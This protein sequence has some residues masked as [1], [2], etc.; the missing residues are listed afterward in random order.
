MTS[1]TE[2]PRNQLQALVANAFRKIEMLESA[3]E[4]ITIAQLVSM[5]ART[6]GSTT[7]IDVFERGER[8]TYSE[9]DR[10]SNKYA[11]AL[12][13]FGVRKHDRIR[14][15]LPNRIAFPILWFAIAKL[16]AVIVP[17]N[18]RYTP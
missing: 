4:T 12:R 10:W 2:L 15:M 14:V 11:R 8:A 17:I 13:V 3:Y 7:A 16:G 5:R 6:H 9:M 1:P 18:M